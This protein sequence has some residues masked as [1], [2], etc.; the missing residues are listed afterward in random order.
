MDK[1]WIHAIKWSTA[2][3][4]GVN[5]FMKFVENFNGREGEI[6]CPCKGCL[7][8]K[9]QDK[10]IVKI[11]LL[12]SGIDPGYTTWFY[13]GEASSSRIFGTPHT[14]RGDA[15]SSDSEETIDEEDDGVIDMLFD[16]GQQYNQHGGDNTF[17][18]N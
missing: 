17:V 15:S 14:S 4:D 6:R 10:N 18:G 5:S 2:Y 9:V 7:N 1:S 3:I 8:L 11:H 12:E 13:H 16:L